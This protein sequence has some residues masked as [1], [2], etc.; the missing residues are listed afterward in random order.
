MKGNKKSTS[1]LGAALITLAISATATS[2]AASEATTAYW[3]DSSGDIVRNGADQCYRTQFWTRENA[4]AA[5]ESA[6]IVDTDKDGIVNSKDACPD[7]APGIEVDPR[8]CELDSDKDGLVNRLDSCPDTAAGAKV[9]AVGC[10]IVEVVAVVDT[11]GDGIEDGKDNCALTP[12]GAPVNANGCELDSDGDNVVDSL[13]QCSSTVIGHKVDENGCKLI[14][15]L[16][17]KAV[18]FSSSSNGL[19]DD[20]TATLDEVA[21]TLKRH[22]DMIIEVAG[23]S[24]SQ[25][26]APLNN[27]LSKNRASSVVDYLVSKGVP[28]ASLQA[29]GYGTSSPIADNSSAAGR[30][31]NRRVELRVVQ[32]PEAQEFQF[33]LD[34]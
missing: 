26:S 1:I 24:D 28:A 10:V 18:T 20:S 22:P 5:C 30:A 31:Q 33:A 12:A 32:Q 19:K 9:D 16:T 14:E 4:I 11:D 8:G 3:T 34:L 21:E 27:V 17:I 29:K 23:Y 25:G 6:D 7:N 13:D 15:T 2:V